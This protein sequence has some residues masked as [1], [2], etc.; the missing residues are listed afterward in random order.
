MSP[1]PPS[2][3]TAHEAPISIGA[4]IKQSGVSRQTIHFYVRIGLL[5]KPLRTSRTYALYPRETVGLLSAIRECQDH[6][7]LS[8]E[9]IGGILREA[10]YDPRRVRAEL[11]DRRKNI[12]SKS[13]SAEVR[14][15]YLALA[16]VLA[17][18]EPPPPRGWLDDLRRYG[19]L[20]A[21]SDRLPADTAGLIHSL[22]KLCRL[23]VRL[24]EL[25]PMAEAIERAAEAEVKAFR[26]AVAPAQMGRGDY[27]AALRTLDMFSQ[28]A[29]SARRDAFNTFFRAQ[30]YKPANLFIGPNQ[31]HVLPSE[32]LLAEMG[33]NREIDRLLNGLDRSPRNRK[34]LA[35]LAQAYFLRSDW[36]NLAG[37]STRILELDPGNVRA[38]ADLSR[39]LVYMG[40]IDQC[41]HL[42][43]RRLK[44]GSD[45][46]LKFR[47]GQAV[48]LQAREAGA[49]DMLVAVRRKQQ[50]AAEALA[51][52]RHLPHIRRWIMLDS[53]LD[54]LTVSD[55]LQLNQP[56]FAELDE[57][58]REYRGLPERG[59]SVLSRISLVM[60]KLLALYALY[61]V[62]RRDRHPSAEQ[63]LS[64]I[65]AMD[66]H[67]VLSR[68]PRQGTAERPAAR[69]KNIRP[70]ILHSGAS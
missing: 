3:A 48:L 53:A 13:R 68:R 25:Q 42:L 6:L 19:F 35:D 20:R 50:L 44:A 40:D 37:V 56:T 49:G 69:K 16:Q 47:L 1:H 7:R 60:G 39:S 22:W 46:L 62:C 52:A 12:S 70:A 10:H 11:E 18:L 65:I 67:N 43:E 21:E 4:V 28:Y 15:Q 45:P 8:L 38:T 33:L 32:T 14:P 30:T 24:E 17:G 63:L 66:P 41:I 5:P 31:K 51:E 29:Q 61:L 26:R 55:P 9:E 59:R 27:T 64:E 54:S 57:L 2:A 58:N 36:F 34:A 23:G